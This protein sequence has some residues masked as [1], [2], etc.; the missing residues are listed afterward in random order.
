MNNDRPVFRE[1]EL[2]KEENKIFLLANVDTDEIWI[3]LE[4]LP[5]VAI[6][7]ALCD[8]TPVLDAECGEH[9]DIPR[10]FV[11]IV[12]AIH[13][14]GGPKD[15]VEALQKREQMIL[16]DLAKKRDNSQQKVKA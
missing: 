4:A 3:D 9:G 12:W 16:E 8:G 15:I 2:G 6:I 10:S 11:N 13:E 5:R 14:W 1:Y 7:C